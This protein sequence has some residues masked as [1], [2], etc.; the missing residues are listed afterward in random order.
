MAKKVKS[1]V[2]DSRWEAFAERYAFDIT[3]FAI[4]VCGMDR[5]T[6]QQVD[7]FDSVGSF[8]SRTTVS[9][10]HGTGKTRSFAVIALWHMLCYADSNTYLTAPKL[11]TLQE[12]IWKEL[13]TLKEMIEAGPHGWISAYFEIKAKKVYVVGASMRWFITCRTAPRGSPE[14]MA[15]THNNYLLWLGD[16]ASGIPDANLKVIAGA[17]TDKRNRFALASQPTRSSGFF[18]DTHHAWSADSVDAKGNRGIW[19]ALIFNSE[20]SPIVSDEFLRDKALE[21]GGTDSVEYQI[22]VQGRFPEHS[23]KYLIGRKSIEA[24]LGR[25][26]IKDD[27]FYGNLL[28]VDV[29]AGVYRDKTVATHARVLGNDPPEGLDPRKMDV[30]GYPVYTNSL[31]WTDAAARVAHTASQL[32]NCTVVVD[33]GGQGVQFAKLLERLEVPNIIKVQWGEPNFRPEYK[34]RFVNQRAQCYVHLKFAIEQG[35]VGLCREQTKDLLDQGAR[36]PFHFDDRARWQMMS[37]ADMAQKEG[38]PS[39]DLLDTLAM[40]YLE[41]VHYIQS[42]ND[43]TRDAGDRRTVARAEVLEALGL[44]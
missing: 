25:Q 3:R 12:G 40:G 16:E 6:W 33:V 37:K 44:D 18:Y 11:S 19:N 15:G 7:L 41:K 26:V 2:N 1:L 20:E 29:A 5:I 9:S 38:L 31:D 22:K 42:D 39:P 21:Y 24:C 34:A 32:S 28:L 8:G 17:L 4:E 27:D 30:K 35:R 10:G 43:Q 36:L 23:D 14:N 13:S